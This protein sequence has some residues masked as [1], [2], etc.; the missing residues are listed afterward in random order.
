MTLAMLRL[1]EINP[2][3]TNNYSLVEGVAGAVVGFESEVFDCE[4]VL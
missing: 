1:R 3:I 4:S 2:R